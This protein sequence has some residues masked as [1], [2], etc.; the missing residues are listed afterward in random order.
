[1][2]QNFDKVPHLFFLVCEFLAL[3]KQS[4]HNRHC[5][6]MHMIFSEP[7]SN[8]IVGA[9]SPDS[10]MPHTAESPVP[11]QRS[12][13]G[14]GRIAAVHTVIVDGSG[15][16]LHGRRP[17]FFSKAK[18]YLALWSICYVA[19]IVLRALPTINEPVATEIKIFSFEI[20][21]ADELHELNTLWRLL[22]ASHDAEYHAL[23]V[24]TR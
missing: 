4:P 20:R 18:E 16:R 13:G 7:C 5:F 17:Y 2:Q 9:K 11:R 10:C 23:R 21:E 19:T 22:E 6:A 12:R 3:M 24:E 15:S 8:H 14:H 1:M